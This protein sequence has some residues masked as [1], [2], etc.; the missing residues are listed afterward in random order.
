MNISKY[1]PVEYENYDKALQIEFNEE[2]EEFKASVLLTNLL[3]WMHIFNNKKGIKDLV[4]F[5]L[6]KY[7]NMTFNTIQIDMDLEDYFFEGNMEES[8]VSYVLDYNEKIIDVDSEIRQIHYSNDLC[9]YKF[10]QYGSLPILLITARNYRMPLPSN[11]IYK[12][13]EEN[14]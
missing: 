10:Y 9:N 4:E 13:L 2:V 11:I 5:V 8:I 1:Y 6:K 14:K 7:P 12:F 3:E